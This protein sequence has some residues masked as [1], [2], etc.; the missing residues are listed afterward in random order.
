MSQVRTAR[1]SLAVTVTLVGGGAEVP[2][3]PMQPNKNMA[4]TAAREN[5]KYR[6][7]RNNSLFEGLIN[8][9]VV[10]LDSAF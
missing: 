10:K 6:F 2:P 1:V 7:I 3:L 8:R 9:P 4:A 5:P